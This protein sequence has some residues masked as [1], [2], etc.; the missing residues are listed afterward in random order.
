MF[1][2]SSGVDGRLCLV[3]WR[4][5]QILLWYIFLLKWGT[6]AMSRIVWLSNTADVGVSFFWCYAKLPQH[7][8]VTGPHVRCHC[9]HCESD[10]S[11]LLYDSTYHIFQTLPSHWPFAVVIGH[12]LFSS[13]LYTCNR[14]AIKKIQICFMSFLHYYQCLGRLNNVEFIPGLA[15]AIFLAGIYKHRD[16]EST[17]ESD[18]R[19]SSRLVTHHKISDSRL[20]D[21]WLIASWMTHDSCLGDLYW[22]MTRQQVWWNRHATWTLE[23]G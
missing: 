15:L 17:H 9:N 10:L 23:R 7:S 11:R 4:K 5:R 21:L 20:K 6:W 13:L 8:L 18:L 19:H 3:M 14:N 2:M 16:L 22:L 12:N 1:S